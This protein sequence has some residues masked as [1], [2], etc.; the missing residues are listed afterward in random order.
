MVASMLRRSL[1]LSSALL[2]SGCSSSP[3]QVATS[4]VPAAEKPLAACEVRLERADGAQ[5][6][7]EYFE[8]DLAPSLVTPSEFKDSLRLFE[9]ALKR[10]A[11]ADKPNQEEPKVIA[12]FSDWEV[13]GRDLLRLVAEAEKALG[14]EPTAIFTGVDVLSYPRVIAIWQ[15]ED[16]YRAVEIFDNN[17]NDAARL[18]VGA[19]VFAIASRGLENVERHTGSLLEAAQILEDTRTIYPHIENYLLCP[20]AEADLRRL[21]GTVQSAI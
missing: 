5:T 17:D 19:G 12:G 9:P 18:A 8:Y 3:K 20:E 21:G 11:E 7:E 2:V 6:R 10:F 16:M 15:R 14:T 13:R 4:P 1:V